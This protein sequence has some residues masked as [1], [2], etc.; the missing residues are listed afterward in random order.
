MQVVA[1]MFHHVPPGY[2]SA[3]GTAAGS[4]AAAAAAPAASLSSSSFSWASAS[5]LVRE[6]QWLTLRLLKSFHLYTLDRARSEQCVACV[7]RV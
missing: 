1:Q 3:V 4:T 5:A 6:L 2:G 7:F